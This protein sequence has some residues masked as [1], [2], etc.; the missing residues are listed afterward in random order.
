MTLKTLSFSKGNAKLGKHTLILSLPAGRTCPGAMYC[1]AFA[2]VSD[3]GKRTIKDTPQT[4][5][6]CFAA[7]SEVQY[8]AVY[9][10]RAENLE[11]IVDSLSHGVDY[12]VHLLEKSIAL[13]RTKHTKLVRIHESGDFFSL[14]YLQAW[15][16][17]AE[18]NPDLE[19]YCY[20]KSL[21]YFLDLALPNNFYMTASY[22]GKFDH[23]IDAGYFKRYSKVFMYEEDAHNAGL[24]VDHDDSHCF[25]DLPFALLV[26]G[27]Q[28]KGSEWGKA[29]R[30]RRNTNKFS[31]YNK[32]HLAA[33]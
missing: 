23:F 28:P 25:G 6:R 32:K 15:V 22:G 19:F 24:D 12:C 29:I 30:E 3:A 10:S 7:S 14:A 26:H 5:F 2:V 16:K 9:N 33:A 20:S 31:G 17:V 27:T 4:I 11:L 8:D 1:K 21:E 18:R 13:H